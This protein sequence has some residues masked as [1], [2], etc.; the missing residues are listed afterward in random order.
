MPSGQ[1]I[2][3]R[4]ILR[5]PSRHLKSETRRPSYQSRTA[6]APGGIRSAMEAPLATTPTDSSTTIEGPGL[7]ESVRQH[8]V[9]VIVIAVLFGALGFLFGLA[10]PKTYTSSTK[11]V[12]VEPQNLG[13]PIGV[14]RYTASMAQFAQDDA[15]LKNVAPVAGVS[16]ANLRKNVANT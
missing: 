7:F 10:A 8:I 12:L 6:G 15:V 4:G 13:G 5:G 14:A 3:Y 9:L 16:L 1:G 2:F 11:L